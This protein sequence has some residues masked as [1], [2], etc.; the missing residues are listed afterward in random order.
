VS[1]AGFEPTLASLA[2]P[3]VILGLERAVYGDAEVADARFVDWLYSRNPAGEGMVWYAATGDAA[4][5]SAGQVAVV[6]LRVEAPGQAGVAGL[7]LNVATHPAW[8]GRGIF[9]ALLARAVAEN[10]RRG[11]RYSFALPNPSST[12]AFLRH[13]GFADAGRVPL[14]LAPLDAAALAATRR[15]LARVGVGLGARLL[16]AHGA[17]RRTRIPALPVEEVPADWAGFDAL[18]A[19]LRPGRR[20]AVVRDR[21]FAAWRFGACPTRRY[22]LYVARSGG[23]VAGFVVTR[24]A[25]VLSMPAGLV[26]DLALVS[27]PGA[28]AAGAAL[29]RRAFEEFATGG[30]ALAASLM[31]PHLGEYRAL[32]AAGFFPCPRPLEP[33]PF[34]VVVRPHAPGIEPS[35]VGWYLSMAD[36]DVV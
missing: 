15:G 25:P 4:V 20:V 1:A 33:Q 26:V 11:L 6:P 27:G 30:A 13:A 7:V 22:R 21:A 9:A 35:L 8:R 32:R 34:R 12:P 31:L 2:S 5:P 19:R 3:G 28:P 10:A 23:D 14:L 18:W 24:L 36:Y 29:L 16:A 17:A